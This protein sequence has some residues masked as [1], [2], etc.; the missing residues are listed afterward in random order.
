MVGQG[1]LVLA[2]E[3]GKA[4]LYRRQLRAAAAVRLFPACILIAC[5]SVVISRLADFQPGIVVGFIAS[6]VVL[7]HESIP[8]AER[9][10]AMARVA[11]IMLGVSMSA[12]LVAIPLH[13]L[14][15][16]SPSL[17]TAIPNATAVSIFVV[18]LEGLLFNLMPLEFMDGWRIWKWNKLAW[19]GLFVPTAFLFTQVLF[20]AE[21]SYFDFISSH[22]S[23]GGMAIIAL[24]LAATWGTWM[25]LR[26]RAERKGAGAIEVGAESAGGN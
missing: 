12:W 9:G 15:R 1:V 25:Y 2:Y 4:W 5:A 17:W 6:A 18:C 20:N 16:S 8:P 14:Y 3:G 24:Y 26:I 21:K 7:E 22:R 23:I 13:T 10:K 19:L 11:A